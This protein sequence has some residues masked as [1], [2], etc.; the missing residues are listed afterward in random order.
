MFIKTIK[1]SPLFID[2]LY[3]R[4]DSCFMP[5]HK[6]EILSGDRICFCEHLVKAINQCFIQ[7]LPNKEIE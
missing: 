5:D 7:L 2:K 1:E 6:T 4:T 3:F